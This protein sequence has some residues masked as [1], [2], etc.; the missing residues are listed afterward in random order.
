MEPSAL[1]SVRDMWVTKTHL[2]TAAAV[3][4]AVTDFDPVPVWSMLSLPSNF[5]SPRA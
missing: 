5:L 1:V 2:S 3:A 4:A